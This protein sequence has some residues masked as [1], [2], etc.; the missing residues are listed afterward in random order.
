[1]TKRVIGR[2]TLRAPFE[3][4]LQQWKDIIIAG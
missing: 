1:M 2:Y 3:T 4:V